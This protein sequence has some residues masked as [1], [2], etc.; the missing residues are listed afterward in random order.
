[1]NLRQLRENDGLREQLAGEYVLGTLRGGARRRFERWLRDDAVLKRSVAEWQDRLHPMAE[2]AP[3]AQ[4]SPQVWA[5]IERR[6]APAAQARPARRSFWLGLREDLG[7]WRGL[8]MVSTAAAT[9]LLTVLLTRLPEPGVSAPAYV[10]TLADDKSQTVML[11]TGDDK[12]RVMTVKVVT[13]Q[14]V[15]DDKSLELWAVRKDGTVRSL[16]LVAANG[17]VTLPLPENANPDNAP[18]LAITLEK[19]G[20]SGNPEAPGGPIVYKGAWLRV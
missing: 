20:G 1:M 7:F 19:K 3:A 8:G 14:T 5:A 9:I 17:V 4:P 16:G 12:R 11:I 15:A 2:F 18:V 10:A 13:P 6:I